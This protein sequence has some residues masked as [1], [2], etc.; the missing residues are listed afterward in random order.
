MDSIEVEMDNVN[1]GDDGPNQNDLIENEDTRAEDLMVNDTNDMED[2]EAEGAL[3][4]AATAYGDMIKHAESF[5]DEDKTDYGLIFILAATIILLLVITIG[6][7]AI[8]IYYLFF[9]GYDMRQT[10]GEIMLYVVLGICGVIGFL[11]LTICGLG[12]FLCY[13]RY[14]NQIHKALGTDHLYEEEEDEVD[15][16]TVARSAAFDDQNDEM[17]GL[18][19][20]HEGSDSDSD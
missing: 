12:W 15:T 7:F 14:K 5:D 18:Q 19:E 1:D 6:G 17:N 16:P 3:H 10:I 11:N 9:H 8:A 13:L 20:L 2:E 4:R